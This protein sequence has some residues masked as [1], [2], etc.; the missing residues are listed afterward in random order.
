[1]L[2]R[3]SP[4]SSNARTIASWLCCAASA[5]T[6]SRI[7]TP[8]Q[9]HKFLLKAEAGSFREPNAAAAARQSLGGID[10]GKSQRRE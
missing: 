8:Q 6:R 3:S 9:A 1:V 10:L 4:A 7:G 5:N 2:S